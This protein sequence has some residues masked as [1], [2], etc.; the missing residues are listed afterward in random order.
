MGGAGT[1]VGPDIPGQSWERVKC[2]ECN[3]AQVGL[4]VL[5]DFIVWWPK[6]VAVADV[7]SRPPE[8]PPPCG[9]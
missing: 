4:P 5:T 2:G 1:C 9:Q 8:I 3:A 6:L 7:Q